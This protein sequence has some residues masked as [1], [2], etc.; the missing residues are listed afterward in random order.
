MY[1]ETVRD[2]ATNPRNRGTLDDA[3]AVGHAFYRRCGD[4][5]TLYFKI[6][7]EVITKAQFTA[8]GCGPSVAAGSLA[9]TLLIGQ[10]VD[11][12][13]RLDAYQFDQALGGLPVPKRHAILLVLQ[14]LAEA[15]GPR[16]HQI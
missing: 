6:E 7:D 10:S 11:D 3:D 8:A 2:H 13:R 4:K 15:L 9:T 14:C 5:M 1:S 16:L 12:A